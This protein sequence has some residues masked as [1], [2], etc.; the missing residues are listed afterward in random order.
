MSEFFGLEFMP[1]GYCIRWQPLLVGVYVASDVLITLS[2]YA[3]PAMLLYF[4]RRRPDVRY[5]WIFYLFAAFIFLCGTT[6]IVGVITLWIPAYGIDAMLKAITAAVSVTTAIVLF[7][8]IPRALLFRSPTELEVVNRA[9]EREITDRVEAESEL[10]NAKQQAEA[11]SRAKSLFLANMSHEIRTPMNSVLGYT[12]LLLESEFDRVETKQFLGVIRRNGDH[13][14]RILEDILEM[15][16]IES[17]KISVEYSVVGLHELMESVASIMRAKALDKGL[18]FQV[19]FEAE[20]G[21]AILTD[22]T[23]VRQI[24]TNVIGNAIKFTEAGSV[25]VTV[26]RAEG[27]GA[28]DDTLEFEVA[29]TG[30]G[31]VPAKLD[32]LFHPFEQ[33]ETTRK[34]EGTGLGLAISRKL[35]Q[36]LRGDIFVESTAGKGSKFT[37]AIEAVSV[38]ALER[39]DGDA[40]PEAL[41]RRLEGLRVLLA[42]DYLDSRELVRLSLERLG[43]FVDCVENGKEAVERI[44]DRMK[45]G[46]LYDFVLMDMQMPVMSG[47]SAT[48]EIRR[49][50]FQ[51]PVL[52]L[53]A[54][55]SSVDEEMCKDA[56]CDAFIPKPVDAAKL[57]SKLLLARIADASV[58]L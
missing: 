56:G 46:E 28:S 16:R 6:H 1:H 17:G 50:G 58:S 24:L 53:T 19:R 45:S 34:F 4:T 15:A 49:M 41:G 22:P 25:R 26:R 30:I 21:A 52:A 39:E 31:I 11:A 43:M 54:Y 36:L 32:S 29:D 14:M 7:G 12:D 3:I 27:R 37:V 51:R 23:R 40:P 57:V 10:L 18:D 9:L 33:L 55:A 42:E 8:A 47:Y 2:Y 35:A 48:R 38:L 44:E 5:N 20:S 13:L